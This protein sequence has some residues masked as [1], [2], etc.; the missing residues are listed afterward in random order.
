MQ[1]NGEK[2]LKSARYVQRALIKKGEY[3]W[4]WK[5]L[6]KDGYPPIMIG[7]YVEEKALLLR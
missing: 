3:T 7:T 1:A 2:S 6:K 5:G 4:E